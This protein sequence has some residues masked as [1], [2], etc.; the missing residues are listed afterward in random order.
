MKLKTKS[1]NTQILDKK[2]IN[3]GKKWKVSGEIS[4][5]PRQFFD[6]LVPIFNDSQKKEYSFLFMIWLIGA[7]LFIKWWIDSDHVVDYT[8]FL[9]NS[10]LLLWT[11]VFP[12]YFF[13]FV[14]RIKRVNPEIKIPKEWRVA[15]IA[16]RAPTEPF[17][18]VKK[19]LLAMR[20]QKFPHD[21]WLADEDPNPEIFDWCEANGIKLCS[22]KGI[23]EYHRESWPRRTKCKEGNLA[24]FYDHFGYLKYDFVVQMDADHVPQHGYLEAMLRPFVNPEVGYVSAPSICDANAESSWAARGRLHAEAIMHG[25]LQAGYSD[26]YAPLCIGSHYAIRT[27]ALKEIGGIGPE[28][29]EDHSTTLMM[30][31]HG[32]KGIHAIDAIASGNGPQTLADCIT[33]E[34]QWS[35][36][37]MVLLLTEMPR[38]WNNLSPKL[39]VQFLFSQLWYPVF[40]LIMLLGYLMPI[41]A[42]LSKKPWVSVGYFDFIAH[43]IPLTFSIL[44]ITWFLKKNKLLRPVESPVMSWEMALFQLVRW[45]WAL[46]GSIMGVINVLGSK[47]VEFKVTPKGTKPDP[48]LKW[49]VL[50]PYLLIVAF[51]FLPA[52]YIQNA[53]SA[54]GY[55]FF[56]ILNSAI[57]IG[58][59]LSI[60]L[61]HFRETKT[62]AW[63]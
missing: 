30:N 59:M 18:M 11:V 63:E 1:A 8:R 51:T 24:Y 40:G 44:A 35:R 7:I 28:L 55:H 20:E 17:E 34:F 38:Q 57:N 27:T 50:V 58:V 6:Y 16:T 48:S 15:M 5:E 54:S 46:Y 42:I 19:T 2:I 3:T 32:W 31:S 43:S 52:I 21:T 49:S 37:L 61:I 14:S 25:P 45:P 22:R 9:I 33:Q 13:F 60:V 29:A 39:R 4:D 47:N 36:S 41:I 56:L 62:E 23:M 53:G 12:G 10:I 26:G